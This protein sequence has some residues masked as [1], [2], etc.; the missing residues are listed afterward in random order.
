MC[1]RIAVA[2]YAGIGGA[3]PEELVDNL[4]HCLFLPFM[5]SSLCKCGQAAYRHDRRCINL[6]NITVGPRFHH[7]NVNDSLDGIL[8]LFR[9]K[10][11]KLR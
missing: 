7:C 2:V 5:R 1:E 10:P 8:Q 6:T 11:S 3:L 9:A 4:L